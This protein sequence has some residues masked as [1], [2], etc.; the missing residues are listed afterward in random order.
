[1]ILTE[2]QSCVSFSE[3]KLFLFWFVNPVIVS[4]TEQALIRYFASRLCLVN[5]GFH[6]VSLEPCMSC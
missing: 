5:I 2:L 3:A 4:L 6:I 1:M